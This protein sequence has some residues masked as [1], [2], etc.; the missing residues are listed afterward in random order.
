MKYYLMKTLTV[1]DGTWQKLTVLKVENK[2]ATLDEVI[3]NLFNDN[4]SEKLI[5][6]NKSPSEEGKH[7]LPLSDEIMSKVSDVAQK[8]KEVF[9][10]IPTEQEVLEIA[11][12]YFG[13]FLDGEFDII[14]KNR[15]M[16]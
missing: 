16:E 14:K 9:G 7:T 6:Q 15:S 3:Q 5:M 4:N 11:L 13:E 1:S 8:M 12:D 10:E 2:S